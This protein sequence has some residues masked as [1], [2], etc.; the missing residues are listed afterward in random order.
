MSDP[1]LVVRACLVISALIVIQQTGSARVVAD[2]SQ[3]DGHEPG[4]TTSAPLAPAIISSRSAPHQ[5]AGY[6]VTVNPLVTGTPLTTLPSW[7]AEADQAVAYFG[8]AVATAGDVNGDGFSDVIVGAAWYDNGQNDTGRAYVYLGSPSGLVSTPAWTASSDRPNSQFGAAVASAGDVNGD[9]FGDIIVGAVYYDNGQSDEGRAYLY[10]G[11]PAGLA[12]SPAWTVEGDQFFAHLG[13]SLSGAGDVNGDGFDDVIVGAPG[14]DNDQTDEGRAYLYFGSASGLSATPGWTVEGNQAGA[15]LGS[16]NTAGDVNGDG[17]SDVI[18]GAGGYDND[19]M[20][21][22]RVYLYL[23]SASGLS[24]TPAWTA[25]SDQ[26]NASFNAVSTAG[27][28]NGDGFSDVIVGARTYD[29]NETD[30]G[31]VFLY[32]GSPSGLGMS[33]AWTAES[34]QAGAIFGFSAPT[35]GDVNGD[36]FSDVIVGA[37]HYSNGQFDEGRA[38]LY[39]GSASGLASSPAWIAESDEVDGWLGWSVATA[40]D[41]NGDGFSDVIV[42]APH[43]NNGQTDEGRALVFQGGAQAARIQGTAFWD[44]NGDGHLDLGE[45]GIPDR[46]VQAVPSAPGESSTNLTSVSDTTAVVTNAQGEFE[47]SVQPGD[48]ALSVVPKGGESWLPETIPVTAGANDVVPGN[49]TGKGGPA[50]DLGVIIYPVFTGRG[51][52]PCPGVT[53]QLCVRSKNLGRLN[54]PQGEVTLQL[55]PVSQVTYQGFTTYNCNDQPP[56]TPLLEANNL[57]TWRPFPPFKQHD[58]C[59]VCATVLVTAPLESVLNATA[60]IWLDRVAQQ[61]DTTTDGDSANVAIVHDLNDTPSLRVLCSH[62][63][64][65]MQV[66]PRGCGPAAFIGQDETLTYL[67]QFQNLG[68]APAFDVIVRDFLDPSLDVTGFQMIDTSHPLTSVTL[69]GKNLLVWSFLDIN[70]PDASTD[71]PGSHGFVRFKVKLRPGLPAGTVIANRA[72]IVFDLNAPV[73]TNEV[74]NV[75]TN[76]GLPPYAETGAEVCNAIDDDCDGTVDGFGTSCGVGD[77]ASSGLCTAG[78]DSCSPGQPSP[79]VCDGSDND[80]N[81]LV[82]DGAGN[83]YFRDADGDGHG[84][85]ADGIQACVQPAG[86]VP[87][88]SD[89]LDADP[90]AWGTPGEV[91]GVSFGA[92]GQTISWQAGTPVGGTV[93]AYDVLRAAGTA[94]D[95]MAAATCMESDDGSDTLATDPES[96]PLEGVFYYLIR[97]ENGCPGVLGIGSLGSGSDGTPRTGRSCP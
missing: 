85:V 22:G 81:A 87:D 13:I 28:V 43:Y 6:S 18:V 32:L 55:P 48:Y 56:S 29:N 31:R 95:F 57:L 38:H 80:C 17:F 59:T 94:V 36:G 54:E 39:L 27:D 2:T 50:R 11:S 42:G 61:Q 12:A 33:P 92:D 70:L 93:S 34:D 21:E 66:I 72:S 10:L 65:D 77:C 14:Y 60:T 76:N 83:S 35:A 86:Y 97:A 58:E 69:G 20:N 91:A 3:A 67:I 45:T 30:E 53:M 49:D 75:V 79:E 52:D 96:P 37:H 68:N 15:A 4:P 82:D 16:V 40:G 9:G 88:N 71:E 44:L 62:D 90:F 63:P 41:V 47:M 89:C 46:I 51:Q 73:V 78:L 1:R 25:E 64:N 74:V 24:A 84:S 23:G 7:S 26:A 19:Q 8:Y 5:R